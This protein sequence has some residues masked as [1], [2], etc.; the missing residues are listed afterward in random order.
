MRKL[1]LALVTL[2]AFA[3]L[4][5][6]QTTQ[7]AAKPPAASGP[8][9]SAAV[10]LEA[11]RKIEDQIAKLAELPVVKELKEIKGKL[12]AAQA[13]ADK[14]IKPLQDQYQ[15]LLQS[16]AGESYQ[17]R[18]R[19]LEDQLEG[20]WQH[21]AAVMTEAGRK[22]YSAR[23]EELRKAASQPTVALGK[24]GLDVPH[25][26]RIDGST[27][28]HPLSVIIACRTFDIP[29]EWIY[30]EPSRFSYYSRP[31]LPEHLFMVEPWFGPRAKVYHPVSA[32]FDIAAARVVAKPPANG[33]DRM[34][35]IINSLLAVSANTHAAYENLI[36]G[37]CDLNL[38]ARGP[39]DDERKLASE[40][41]VKI[42]LEP[43]ARDA[44]VFIVNH[45]NE[46]KGLTRQQA[47]DIYEGKIRTW[48]ELGWTPENKDKRKDGQNIWPLGRERNSGSRELFDSLVMKGRPLQGDKG[49]EEM[50]IGSM[51]GPFN[52]VTQE[53]QTLSYSV[54]YYEHYQALSPYT[55]TLAIDGV[56]P[57]AETIASGKYPL[58][59]E[60]YAACRE[61]EAA[62]S[63]A[64]KMLNWLISPEGQAVIKESGYVPAKK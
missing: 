8:A 51:G 53:P 44:L 25:Y 57:T 64:M 33:Q 38:T 35:I 21:E 1:M 27:S 19:E 17:K 46:V 29:Y 52:R 10:P 50:I 36:N 43:I 39:S 13:A 37:T 18:L 23:H 26:P 2:A 11:T 12:N 20:T 56:E 49:W 6:A 4:A 24:L 58:V 48:P 55:R 40:K 54:Y 60:V 5:Q 15:S 61:G 7:P 3:A 34:A 45:K 63:P 30:P 14:D 32:E 31:E 41:G 28:T 9:T 22:I 59:A 42:R 16:D 62:D 47:V